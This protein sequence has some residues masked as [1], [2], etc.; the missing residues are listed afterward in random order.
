M[1]GRKTKEWHA[2]TGCVRSIANE[3]VGVKGR[4]RY[5]GCLHE[6]VDRVGR[7]MLEEDSGRRRGVVLQ[8]GEV[9]EDCGPC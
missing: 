5:G 3:F 6:C 4:E 1:Y 8:W 7:V 2:A 9:R